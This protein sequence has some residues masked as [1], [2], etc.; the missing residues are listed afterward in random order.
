MPRN[1]DREP[2]VSSYLSG[3]Q[4]HMQAAMSAEE[5]WPVSTEIQT[6]IYNQ[7]VNGGMSAEQTSQLVRPMTLRKAAHRKRKQY[8]YEGDFQPVLVDMIVRW[9]D[10]KKDKQGGPSYEILHWQTVGWRVVTAW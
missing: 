6:L 3:G 9:I 8:K 2:Q 4:V 10:R 7:F 1:D 5:P